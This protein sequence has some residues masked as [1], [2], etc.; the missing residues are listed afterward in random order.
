MRLFELGRKNLPKFK[1]LN[2]TPIFEAHALLIIGVSSLQ[3]STNFLRSFSFCGPAL[4]YAGK[5]SAQDDTLP[6]NHSPDASFNT[7]VIN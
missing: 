7:I 5:K 2:L 6:V 3:S 1:F 4:E